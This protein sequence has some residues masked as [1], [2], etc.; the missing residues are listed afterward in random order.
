MKNCYFVISPDFGEKGLDVVLHH[1][2]E[3]SV[4]CKFGI[5]SNSN[6]DMVRHGYTTHNPSFRFIKFEY[7]DDIIKAGKFTVGTSANSTQII[8]TNDL[9]KVLQGVLKAKGMTQVGAT[10]WMHSTNVLMVKKI[11]D[12]CLEYEGGGVTQYNI[13]KLIT[14]LYKC[15]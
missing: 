15:T 1:D 2:M 12:F 6:L 10:E 7:T 8:V 13:P 14:S 9:G 11:A 3:R 4:F 5:T